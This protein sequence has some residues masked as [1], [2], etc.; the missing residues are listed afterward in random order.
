MASPMA[1]IPK[2]P[3]L[4]PKTRVVK[5]ARKNKQ[6]VQFCNVYIGRRWSIGGW[7]LQQSKWANP[8]T[9]KKCGSI[10]IVLQKYK[11]HVLGN[12]D[13]MASLHELDGKVLGCWCKPNKCHGDVLLELIE[14]SKRKQQH[15]EKVQDLE[16]VSNKGLEPTNKGT[17]RPASTLKEEEEGSVPQPKLSKVPKFESK[18]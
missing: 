18:S 8:F 12:K 5:I 14:D 4:N 17:K 3:K 2:I 13:L 7:N 9:I 11:Q 16:T 10:E 1:T 6:I 15:P